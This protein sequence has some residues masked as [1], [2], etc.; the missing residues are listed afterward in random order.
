MLDSMRHE[1]FY[2]TGSWIDESL[3][4]Y[5]GWVER[6][7]SFA[8]EM[9]LRSESGEKVLVFF[10]EDFPE[11]GTPQR[12]RE[13]GHTLNLGDRSYLVH[14]S[15]EDAA[16]PAGLNGQFHGLLADRR[17]GTVTLFNDRYGLRRLCYHEGTDALYF[18]AEAKA[19]LAVCPEVRSLDARALG[20]Y[21]ACG[22]V[23]EGRTLFSGVSV[24]P[25]ASAWVFRGGRLEK[26]QEYFSPREW[27]SQ[28]AMD[29][30]PYYEAVRE[31]FSRSLPRYFA[32]PEKVGLSL[33]GGLDTRM[34][35]AWR[36]P[37]P[38]SLP[39]YTFAGTYREC[40][41]VRIARKV[42]RAC[43]QPH[44]AIEVGSEFLS[45][46][47]HYAQ[48]AVYLTDGCAGVQQAPDL[49]V[50]ELARQIAPVRL[51]GNYGDQVLRHITVFHPVSPTTG[52][53]RKDCM[54]QVAA[55]RETYGRVVQGHAL[56]VAAFRQVPW[57]YQGMFAL[58]SSQLT[59][60]SPYID[61]DLV[62]LVYR[63][64][65]SA[66]A[67]NDLRVRLIEDGDRELAKIRTDL[68]FAGNGL[69]SSLSHRLHDFT[70][71][72]EYAYDYGMPQSL[73]RID[74]M[75]SVFHLERLFLGRHK[76]CHFRVWYRDKLADYVRE[77]LL[78]SR[79]LSRPYLRG[80]ALESMVKGHL[81]GNRNYTTDIHGILTLEHVHRLFLDSQ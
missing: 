37:A 81:K 53:Y 47:P 2:G 58:E 35:L 41:D 7:P 38:A 45:R 62:K 54:D 55:A 68:G 12:L 22:C 14:L 10:G 31:S 75:L 18:G 42:A 43:G 17:E 27:E 46:F 73:A 34:I 78:D 32:G 48:R 11:P 25:N 65:D 71:R 74:H 15:E 61:N 4:V 1:P 29:P 36:H 60:R 9:P 30:G 39:C 50:N 23:L 66:L 13:R 28:T 64:P 24:L 44:Q 59:M 69:T 80:N 20:E 26:Q 79:T 8:A 40:R 52:L 57:S 3:G 70:F 63:A 16:F 49:Y 6:E 51:T 5:V 56:T 76:F 33:T 77:M 19:I 72:T 21:I 67:S